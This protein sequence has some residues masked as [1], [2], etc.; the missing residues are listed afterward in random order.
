MPSF[1]PVSEVA[2]VMER[3]ARPW[4]IAGGWAIDLF[5]GRETREHADVDVAILRRDQIELRSAL[6]TWTFEKV[7]EGQRFPWGEGKWLDPPVHE[8]HADRTAS[9]PSHLEILLNE[10][11]GPT[12]RFRRNVEVT[13]P[14]DRIGMRTSDGVPFLAPEIALLFK[15]KTPTD[16][17]VRDFELVRPRLAAEPREWLRRALGICYPGH[18]WRLLL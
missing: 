17:D 2:S 15:A 10:S 7:V 16:K 18:P 13:R 12:W 1:A 8:V 4:Y 9:S 5:V 6:A 3:F 11:S 14:L